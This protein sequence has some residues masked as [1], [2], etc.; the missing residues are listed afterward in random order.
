MLRLLGLTEADLS[1][2]LTFKAVEGEGKSKHVWLFLWQR[3]AGE[4]TISNTLQS[5]R[6]SF[7]L[8]RPRTRSKQEDV[9]WRT[10]EGVA[11]YRG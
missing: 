9:P 11:A 8:L 2:Q 10:K 7:P 5:W 4:G 3:Y 1:R 6:C